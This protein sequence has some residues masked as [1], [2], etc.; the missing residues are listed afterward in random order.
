MKN[1]IT[2]L[3]SQYKLTQDDLAKKLNVSRQTIISLEKEKYN[4]SILLAYQI[5]QIFSLSIEEVFQFETKGE[6]A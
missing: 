3:R 6:E 5:A 4:P 1:R 2:E